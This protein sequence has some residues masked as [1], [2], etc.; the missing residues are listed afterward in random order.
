MAATEKVSAA[1]RPNRSP[2][3]PM[4]TPPTGRIM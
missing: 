4:I 2:I 1:R 3:W